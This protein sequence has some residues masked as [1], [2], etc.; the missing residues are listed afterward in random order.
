M[1]NLGI[2]WKLLV[3]QLINFGVFFVIFKKFV[4]KPFSRFLS[5]EKKHEE[6]RAKVM[7]KAKVME[8]A[9]FEKEREWKKKMLRE[10]ETSLKRAK[11]LGEK[12]KKEI[13][14]SAHKE[15]EQ[16]LVKARNQTEEER[17]S[18]YREVKNRV[19]ELSMFIVTHALNDY[20][21]QEARE[22]I[23]A[24][25]LKNLTKDLD[26]YENKPTS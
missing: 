9:L 3:A 22:K 7:E 17:E 12:L 5:E 8:E 11:E 2:D 18:L 25:I 16:V 1:E 23:T 10:S 15:A 14:E 20:L 21:T 6:E 24:Y 19:S 13:I 26:S 4:A